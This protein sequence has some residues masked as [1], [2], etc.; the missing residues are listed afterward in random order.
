VSDRAEIMEL[1]DLELALVGSL[2]VGQQDLERVR[3]IVMPEMFRN[4][5]ARAVYRAVCGL[6]AD[7]SQVT[8]PL[9]HKWVVDHPDKDGKHVPPHFLVRLMEIA[10]TSAHALEYADEIRKRFWRTAAAGFS[11]EGEIESAIAALDRARDSL[12]RRPFEPK[13]ASAIESAKARATRD[14]PEFFTGIPELDRLLILDRRMLFT[15]GAYTSQGKTAFALNVALSL[16]HAGHR[17]A[18]Y[19][20]EAAEESLIY[21]LL[22]ILTG[23]QDIRSG[24]WRDKTDSVIDGVAMLDSLTRGNRF[25]IECGLTLERIA[26]DVIENKPDFIVIDYI[27]NLANIETRQRDES[28]AS[29]IAR[30]MSRLE[31]MAVSRNMLVI[32]VSQ[33]SREGVKAERE[34]I[35]SDLRDSGGIEQSSHAVLLGY[36]DGIGSNGYMP[37]PSEWKA[38]VA[39]QKDG[40]IGC[41]T[42]MFDRRTFRFCGR[43]TAKEVYV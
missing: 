13:V 18:L 43:N 36:S 29:L 25:A 14:R 6:V 35:L 41:E 22:S 34:P 17:G 4:G 10:H 12:K 2:M 37:N 31:D 27:Q 42:I 20:Y 40:P 21:R 39:K 38:I 3:G 16:L 1:L 33:I 5:Q 24:R 30:L 32:V 11:Q 15:I 28:R 7:G 23:V 19:S 9:L 26:A 8:L